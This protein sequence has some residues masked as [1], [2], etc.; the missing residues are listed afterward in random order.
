[1]ETTQMYRRLRQMSPGLGNM[2]VI[3]HVQTSPSWLQVSTSF[4]GLKP[5][6]PNFLNL[7]GT[8][9]FILAYKLEHQRSF[10]S[11]R[12]PHNSHFRTCPPFRVWP[13]RMMPWKFCDNI[14][15]GSGVIVLTD[16]RIN[17]HPDRHTD[18]QTDR[19]TNVHSRPTNWYFTENN[20]TLAARVVKTSF[21]IV[22]IICCQNNQ[23]L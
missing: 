8:I 14:S 6:P 7:L 4:P 21:I 22:S 16:I 12:A 1:M 2:Y 5:Q 20:A 23:C 11:T 13:N 10:L 19:R 17:K 3:L 18:R 15:N 9:K